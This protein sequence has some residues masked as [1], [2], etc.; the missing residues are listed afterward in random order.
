MLNIADDKQ[1]NTIYITLKKLYEK[2]LYLILAL[3]FF[4]FISKSITTSPKIYQKIIVMS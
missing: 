3:K 2:S 4:N 1:N